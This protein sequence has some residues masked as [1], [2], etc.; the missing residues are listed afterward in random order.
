MGGMVWVSNT[1]LSITFT[2][3]DQTNAVTVL[4]RATTF[5]CREIHAE[6]N[7]D[8]GWVLP[9]EEPIYSK[10]QTKFRHSNATFDPFGMPH[11]PA[12]ATNSYLTQNITHSEFEFETGGYLL[13]R[14]PVRDGEHGYYRHVVFISPSDARTVPITMGR[15]EVTEILGWDEVNEIV[16]FMA[17]PEQKPAQRHMYKINLRLNATEKSTRVYITSTQPVCLTCDNSWH[18]YRILNNFTDV[19][20]SHYETDDFEIPNNCLFNKIYFSTGFS[21][22]VQECLGPEAPSIYLVDTHT[23]M[24]IFVLNHGEALRYR[25]YNLATPQIRIFN[26]EIRHGFQAQVRLYLPPGMKEEEEIAFPLIL[27][28]DAAP[29]SQLVTE[30]FE[31]D[32]NSYL[33]SQKSMIIAQIDA[34]GSGYQGELM[35]SQIKG[36]L[37][38]VEIEDQL[39]VLRYNL[40]FVVMTLLEVK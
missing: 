24:K 13:K 2:D 21:Y 30:K 17:A 19:N 39:G 29:G 6:N 14:L 16:Y 5:N 1:D 35:R 10:M 38:T 4:C 23:N 9:S 22:Y 33:C 26:V 25:W 18:T 15:F 20:T 12:N 8:N 36:R 34:R 32:W 40:G 27:Q 28:I 3:R 11:D 7:V 37:G 31:I